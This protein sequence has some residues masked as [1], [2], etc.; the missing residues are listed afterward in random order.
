MPAL[1]I[2]ALAI[3]LLSYILIISERIHRTKVAVVGAVLLVFFHVL[4]QAEAFEFI[5]FNTVGLLLGMMLLISV[6]KETG[7]FTYIAIRI[8]KMTGGSR[9]KILLWFSLFTA[10]A[11]ALLDNVTTIL[12]IAPITIL[13]A[14]MLSISP[15]PFLVSEVLASN[16]GGTAT[17]IGDPPNILI[18]SA[19]EIPFI[20][21]L[22]HLGPAVVIILGIT[23]AVLGILFRD[24]LSRGDRDYDRIIAEMDET[25]VIKNRPILKKSILVLSL[26]IAGFLF[27]NLLGLKPATIALGGGGILMIWSGADIEKHLK[28]IEWTTLFFFMGLFILVGGLEKTGVLEK[29]AESIIGISNDLTFLCLALLWISALASS[30]LDNIPFVAAMIP[31]LARISTTLFPNTQGLDEAA[32]HAYYIQQSLPLWWSLA[33]GACLG[34]NGTIVGASANL[35]AAGFSEKTRTPLTFRNYFRYGFPLMIISV[36]ISTV[37]ILLRYIIF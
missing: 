29:L 6:I 34:G 17:L 9:W 14:E 16:I 37:Y 7:A 18:G 1:T 35:V 10:V 8:T 4:T 3:F 5:D 26:T 23:L 21:F 15:F 32:Y 13:I 30:F 36:V 2:T 27:H 22:I 28:E 24:Q 20:D 11:S 25:R 33:L 31:L 19:T 12:L